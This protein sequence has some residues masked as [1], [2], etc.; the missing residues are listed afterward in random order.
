MNAQNP[1]PAPAPMTEQQHL[2]IIGDASYQK[3]IKNRISLWAGR[4]RQCNH[5]M[6]LHLEISDTKKY[7]YYRGARDMAM[8]AARDCQELL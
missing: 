6:L 1:L 4:A 3:L 5:D 8:E 7:H 2:M